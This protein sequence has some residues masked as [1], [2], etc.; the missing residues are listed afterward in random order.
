MKRTLT[1]L[2]SAALA[3]T[4]A[5]GGLDAG[6]APKPK[7]TTRTVTFDYTLF[8]AATVSVAASTSLN[9]CGLPGQCFEIDT[10][11]GEKTLALS[12]SDAS[13]QAVGFQVFVDDVYDSVVTF[14]GS[15]TVKVSPKSGHLVSVRA[16]V[17][18]LCAGVPTEGTFS[19]TITNT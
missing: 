4:P 19:A 15:G 2:A 11:K 14:C 12:A 16:A 6:A 17:S 5:L 7:K 1:L 10:V 18:D 9:N 13:G 3:V 8:S